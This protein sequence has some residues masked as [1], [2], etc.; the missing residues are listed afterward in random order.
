MCAGE[1]H[2]VHILTARLIDLLDHPED[3]AV[4]APLYRRELLYHVLRGPRGG[5]LRAVAMGRGQQRAIGDVLATIHADCTRSFTVPELAGMAAMSESVFYE[6]FRSVTAATP[7]QY[8]KRLRLQEA[9]RRLTRGVTD[10]S[11]AARGVGYASMSQ[12][13]R[14]FS[15]LFGAAPSAIRAR[16]RT[17]GGGRSR[18]DRRV[19]TDEGPAAPG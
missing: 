4:L 10:V 1:D 7:L 16:Q 5:L 14:E 6:A 19:G 8:I 13:S 9:H 3:V 2:A 15:R 18:P 17:D 12:F 11:G